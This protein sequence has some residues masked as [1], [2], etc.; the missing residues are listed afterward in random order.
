MGKL[1]H[2]SCIIFYN[3]ISIIMNLKDNYRHIRIIL[4]KLSQGSHYFVSIKILND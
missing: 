1:L 4:I 2:V 3:Y